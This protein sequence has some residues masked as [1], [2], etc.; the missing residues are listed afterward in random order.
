MSLK[1]LFLLLF[2]SFCSD[3]PRRAKFPGPR[4]ETTD[5]KNKMKTKEIMGGFDSFGRA[6]GKTGVERS[7]RGVAQL[8]TGIELPKKEFI[9]FVSARSFQGGPPL[10]AKKFRVKNF[11]FRF[12]L[13]EN[14]KMMQGTQLQGFVKLTIRIDQLEEDGRSDPL[15]RLPGDLWGEASVQVGTQDIQLV[16]DKR[17]AQ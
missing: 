10:A 8:G 3:R 2:L 7:L 15:S 4:G 14:D 12:A 1:L 5:L 6:L 9:I 13:T 17:V 11:P 16:I